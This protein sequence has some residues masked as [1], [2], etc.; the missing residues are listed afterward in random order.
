MGAVVS[1]SHPQTLVPI[2]SQNYTKNATISGAKSFALGRANEETIFEG[3]NG[4]THSSPSLGSLQLLESGSVM[5]SSM[6][7]MCSPKYW[8]WIQGWETKKDW[9]NAHTNMHMIGM[10]KCQLF[11]KNLRFSNSDIP[12][13]YNKQVIGKR[14]HAL[15]QWSQRT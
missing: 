5:L 12:D 11:C 9:I 1:S 4:L 10:F 3:W 6:D 8:I 7:W 14:L 15:T 2:S 13:A